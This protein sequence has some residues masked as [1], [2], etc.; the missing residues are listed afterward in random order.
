MLACGLLCCLWGTCGRVENKQTTYAKQLS[1]YERKRPSGELSDFGRF[2]L[3]WCW[4]LNSCNFTDLRIG[5]GICANL[6]PVEHVEFSCVFFSETDWYCWWPCKSWD[7]LPTNWCRISSYFFHQQY[8]FFWGD[9]DP[10]SLWALRRRN[11]RLMC[12]G[13]RGLNLRGKRESPMAKQDF[14]DDCQ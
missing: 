11:W 7:K 10:S 1:Q 8:H 4:I 3:G 14:L 9:H 6:M 2:D 5:I 12:R 13:C